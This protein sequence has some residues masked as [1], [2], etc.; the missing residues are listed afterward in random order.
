LKDRLSDLSLKSGN[1]TI[2]GPNLQNLFSNSSD[3]GLVTG[4]RKGSVANIQLGTF[5]YGQPYDVVL[6]INGYLRT[7]VNSTINAGQTLS[8]D[9]GSLTPGD[10]NTDGVINSFDLFQIFNNWGTNSNNISDLNGDGKI[11]T[12]DVSILYNYFNQTETI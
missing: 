9:F 7:K 1:L 8:L 12:F 5:L 3:Q 6:R 4:G 2:S 11:N 10:L